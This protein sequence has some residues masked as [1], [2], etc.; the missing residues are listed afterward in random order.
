MILTR[1]ILRRIVELAHSVPEE[2]IGCGDCGDCLDRFA[3]LRLEGLDTSEALPLVEQHLGQC[4]ECEEE[5]EALMA[6]LRAAEQA[7]RPLWRR[8]LGR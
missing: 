5:F 6:A 8:I 4:H 2:A 7:D 3:E 1:P